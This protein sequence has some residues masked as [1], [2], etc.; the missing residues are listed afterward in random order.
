MTHFPHPP[1]P[2]LRPLAPGPHSVIIPARNAGRTLGACLD[3]LAAEGVPG[4]N[5]ELIVVDD[6]S[7]DDT[8]CVAARPGVRVIA[9]AGRGPAAARNLGARH[10]TGDV[11]VFLDADTVPLAGWLREMVAPLADPSV[12]AVKGRYY[13]CQ[14]S[15]VAR[16]A[17]LEFE[18]KYARLERAAQVDFVDAGTAAYRREA[19]CG[20]GGFDERFPAQSAE[21]VELAFR[22]AARGA[23]FAFNPRAAVVHEHA[24][25]LD[26]Y[27]VK[28]ARYGFFRVRVYRRYP[29][30][31]LGDSYTPP[32][33]GLQI[34]LAAVTGVLAL[35]SVV[36]FPL[37]RF[38][39][40]RAALAATLA[41]FALTTKPLIER[42]GLRRPTLALAVPGLVYL[43]AW[44]QG[45][46]IL[47]GLLT[48]A[49]EKVR[50][51]TANEPFGG[52]QGRLQ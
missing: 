7:T 49:A 29:Q 36:R 30:K 17:Q 9:G 20:V 32:T 26:E 24:A 45:L 43:R 44:A 6:G 33:M 11:L 37:V 47:A 16:F 41:T 48:L 28:K 18:D 51:R 19:F 22:L 46:G 50:H 27:L 8:A 5:A 40:V 35:L 10:A 14:Q 52:A 25:R 38:P 23:G 4:Q 13:S 21:D 3:G 39:L 15:L 42:A 12:V 1:F 2:G 34:A 31:A